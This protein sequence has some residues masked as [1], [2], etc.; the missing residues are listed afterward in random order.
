MHKPDMKFSDVTY[1]GYLVHCKAEN[2]YVIYKMS[3]PHI[4]DRTDA[5]VAGEEYISDNYP[6]SSFE[7]LSF[8]NQKILLLDRSHHEKVF[9]N[10][11]KFDVI[12][13]S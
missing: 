11:W 8:G 1:D 12:N 6:G 5:M 3:L 4:E 13:I 2:K 7:G 10:G 9:K